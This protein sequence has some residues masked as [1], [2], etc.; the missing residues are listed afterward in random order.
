VKSKAAACDLVSVVGAVIL[1]L[2]WIFQS[3]S[4]AKIDRTITDLDDAEQSYRTYQSN[5]AIFNAIVATEKENDSAVAEIRRAQI[6]NYGLGLKKM[7]ELTGTRALIGYEVPQKDMDDYNKEVHDKAAAIRNTASAR[8]AFDDTVSLML[9]GLGS[10]L[11]LLGS[12]LK[13]VFP[14]PA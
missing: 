13:L 14:T 8:K 6:Y 10:L 1:F 12:M 11:T 2:T 7:A 3:T 4:L 9:Y 5:N